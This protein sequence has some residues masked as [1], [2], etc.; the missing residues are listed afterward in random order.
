MNIEYT[1]TDS[2]DDPDY[3]PIDETCEAG[4]QCE[5]YYQIQPLNGIIIDQQDEINT[6]KEE[7]NK[8]RKIILQIASLIS[9][10]I[11]S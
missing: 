11:N 6:L 9:M 5:C 8:L 7:T 10:Q 4:D 2:E 1:T 3:I